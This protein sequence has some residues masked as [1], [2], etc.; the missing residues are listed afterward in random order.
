MEKC[1][2][3][4]GSVGELINAVEGITFMAI[5]PVN[6]EG[7]CNIPNERIAF[8]HRAYLASGLSN[9]NVSRQYS[10]LTVATPRSS[11]IGFNRQVLPFR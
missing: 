1:S 4:F 10:H 3:Q 2:I 5:A 9:S 7:A 11:L 8:N 6:S